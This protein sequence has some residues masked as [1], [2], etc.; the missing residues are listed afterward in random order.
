MKPFRF[1]GGLFLITMAT[2]MVQIIQTRILSVVAWHHLAFF[3]IGCAMFGLTLGAV[4]VYL[5]KDRFTQSTLSWD[6][7][8]FSAAFAVSIA[9]SLAVQ[10]TLSPVIRMSATAIVTW[11]ELMIALG[12]PFVFSGIVVSLALTRS[13]YPIGK[14][15]GADLAGAA[16]GCLGVLALLNLTDGPAAVLWAAVF[17]AMAPLMFAGSDL[18]EAPATPGRVLGLLHKRRRLLL[19]V[20]LAAATVNHLDTDYRGLRPM[21]IKYRTVLLA[22]FPMFE[23]W[24]TF[25]RIAVYDIAE[26]KPIMWGASPT[27]DPEKWLIDQRHV[28]IDDSAATY[29]YRLEGDMA[30]A[31]FLKYDVTNLAYYLG[32]QAKSL[33]LGSGAGRDMISARIFGVRDITGVEINPILHRLLTAEPGFA[34]FTGI[35]KTK[36]FHFINDEA[37]SWVARNQDRF[38]VIQMSLIDTEAATGAGAFSLT[39]NGLY[40]VESWRLYFQHLTAGGVFSV[41]RWFN[42]GYVNE[43]GRLVSL[44]VA[45][46]LEEGAENPNQ[47]LFLATADSIAN[48]IVSRN[49]LT[50]QA[51]ETLEKTARKLGFKI[52]ISPR[53]PA[54]SPVLGEIL[55]SKDRARMDGLGSEGPIDLTPA[56]DDRPFF[57]NVLPPLDLKRMMAALQQT[58]PLGV[59]SGNLFAAKTLFNLFLIS[60]ILVAATVVMPLRYATKDIGNRLAM[61]GTAYFLLIGI[62]FMV[63][64]ISLIQRFSV[65]LGH[66]THSLSIVLFSLILAT[67]VGSFLSDRLPLNGQGIFRAW[68][69][70]TG[71]Y[72][73]SIP[74]WLEDVT[75]AFAGDVLMIRALITIAVLVPAGLLMGFGFPTGMRMISAV[76]PMPTPWFWG[77]NGAAGVLASAYAVASS[78]TFGISATLAV[79]GVCYLL[80]IAAAGAIGFPRN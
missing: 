65:F 72:L 59:T 28:N 38:D 14:V 29:A 26:R 64:E 44:A 56:T 6:L 40:T 16:M 15:Y 68:A 45:A 39:E 33:V 66:P 73:L 12:V 5:K 21:F 71:G 70:V 50:P 51:I 9:V 19:L 22:N 74:Y 54:A 11:A 1:Y 36:G 18:G 34:D 17:A 46:L 31:G 77:I 30:K 42:P 48:L 53:H 20:L 78:I 55:A 32:N 61:A 67:G 80:L 13:P 69:I 52:V 76:N 75:T 35:N 47:H 63:A 57:F 41:S 37:R 43:T 60:V 27:F 49:P 10:M 3:A 8:A 2:L 7:T 23:E 24:N 79:G 58:R 4:W 62:G 25:S